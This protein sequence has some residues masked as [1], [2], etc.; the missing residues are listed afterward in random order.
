MV[1]AY[2]DLHGAEEAKRLGIPGQLPSNRRIGQR[3]GRNLRKSVMM[4]NRHEFKAT[5]VS[6]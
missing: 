4:M 6:G 2:C 3:F 1:A 5:P